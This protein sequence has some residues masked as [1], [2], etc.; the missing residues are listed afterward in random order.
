MPNGT[1]I[2]AMK[3]DWFRVFTNAMSLV[4]WVSQGIVSITAIP[5]GV[6]NFDEIRDLKVKLPGTSGVDPKGGDTRISARAPRCTDLEKGI[7]EK[8]LVNNKS[9]T[10]TDKFHNRTT[11]CRR[12]T[13]ICGSSGLVRTCWW[14]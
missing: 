11:F 7:G 14:R 5:K 2:Y 13:V 10:L 4:P 9:I 3:A 12:V 1:S 8:G 6:I